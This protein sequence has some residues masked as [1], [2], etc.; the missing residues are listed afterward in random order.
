MEIAN[1]GKTRWAWRKVLLSL[2]GENV[3]KERDYQ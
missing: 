2:A 3:L 1:D